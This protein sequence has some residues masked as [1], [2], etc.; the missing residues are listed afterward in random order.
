MT[1]ECYVARN[2]DEDYEYVY[3]IVAESVSEA[4]RIGMSCL[5][6]EYIDVRVKKHKEVDVSNLPIGEIED[7]LWA[8][9]QGLYGYVLEECPRC[10]QEGKVYYDGE[11]YCNNCEDDYFKDNNKA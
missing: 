3:A 5:E 6:C 8:L 11:Y 1:K 2:V 10:K 9:S 7:Y 4:K